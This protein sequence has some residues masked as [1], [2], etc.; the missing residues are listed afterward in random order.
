MRLAHLTD[1]GSTCCVA[2]RTSCGPDAVLSYHGDVSSHTER[3]AH[4][5]RCL[6]RRWTERRSAC[7]VPSERPVTPPPPNPPSFADR[8]GHRQQDRQPMCIYMC[9][10]MPSKAEFSHGTYKFTPPATFTSRLTAPSPSA[11]LTGCTFTLRHLI[12]LIKYSPSLRNRVQGASFYSTDSLKLN[13][14]LRLDWDFAEY[15]LKLIRT[16]LHKR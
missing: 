7:L 9:Y 13:L 14:Q 5:R 16:D 1:S 2:V 3:R 4:Q 11:L 12:T 8:R 6:A 10:A 15:E